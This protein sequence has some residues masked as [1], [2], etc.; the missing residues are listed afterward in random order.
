MSSL[1]FLDSESLKLAE[2]GSFKC[3]IM[4]QILL[5]IIKSFEKT[6][7]LQHLNMK[8]CGKVL[9]D[10]IRTRRRASC[11]AVLS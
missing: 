7:I 2:A 1:P 4:G 10:N 5:P 9:I 3:S 8:G 6:A 11:G